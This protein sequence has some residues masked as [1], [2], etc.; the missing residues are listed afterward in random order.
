MPGP[1]FPTGGIVVD[2]EELPD[3][4]ARGQG[5]FRLQGKYH[6]EQLP[7][8]LQ[9]IVVTELPYG[10]SPDQIVSE[11]VRAARA[12]KI[13]DVTELPKNLSDRNGLRVQIR[14]K[15]GGNV[16][17]LIADLMRHTSLRVTIGINLTVVADGVPRQLD[18]REIVDRFVSFRFE[19]VTRRLEHER[20]ELLRE[21]HRLVALLA[22]L[23]AIDAVI[24]IVRNA[25]DD[26]DAREKL[27]SELRVELHGSSVPVPIDDEQAQYILDMP[28]KRLSRLNRFKLQEERETKGRRVDEI[29]RILDDYDELREIVVG[30]LRTTAE[31]LGAPRRTLL[32]G[33]TRV[34]AG[35]AGARCHGAPGRR[36][37][38]RRAA[39]RRGAVRHPRRR[40]RHAAARRPRLARAAQR[41][42]RRRGRDRD[43]HRHRERAER[44]HER[45]PGAAPARRRRADRVARLARRQGG[46]AV[47]GIASSRAAAAGAR[48]RARAAGHRAGRDQALRGGVFAG[49]HMGGSPAI[50]LPDGDRVVAVVAHGDGDEI[51]LHSAHGRTLR[52]DAGK[53]RPVKSAAAGGVAGMNLDRGDRVVAAGVGDRRRAARHARAGPRQGR[54]ARRVPGQG[55]RHGRRRERQPGR[56]EEGAGRPGR[57]RGQPRGRGRGDGA[58]GVRRRWR[59][60]PSRSWSRRRAPRSPV[61]S[62]TWSSATRWSRRSASSRRGPSDRPAD[63][64]ARA[65]RAAGARGRAAVRARR[66]GGRRPPRRGAARG[67]AIGAL[68]SPTRSGSATS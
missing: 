36:R 66:H 50:D 52:F 67:L 6:I 44:L 41:R 63:P 22:A 12:E 60:S 5:T 38:R 61:T 16:T 30:E 42:R 13:T 27:K 28:I 68:C 48:G 4:Y 14:C 9:A 62:S 59:G 29:G 20:T 39:H 56:A 34:A 53:V 2:P 35:A 18:L 37:H 8:N 11:V 21:L 43:L 64:V 19:V 46:G 45:R 47:A 24:R 25:E 33:E 54:A 58:D 55:T 31:K 10:V 15:R 40:L 23:D 17:K 51:L 26:D 49:S 1:D 32:G 3:A 65:A 7:G 57:R